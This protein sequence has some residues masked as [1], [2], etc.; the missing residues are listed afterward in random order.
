[1]ALCDHVR[2][3]CRASDL[4]HAD[5]LASSAEGLRSLTEDLL[6]YAASRGTCAGRARALLS[7]GSAGRLERSEGGGGFAIPTLVSSPPAKAASRALASG[8]WAPDRAIG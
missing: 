7:G 2:G 1:F 8:L 6:G 3:A 4:P 5:D